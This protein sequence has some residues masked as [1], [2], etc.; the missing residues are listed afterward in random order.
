M[1]YFIVF[2]YFGK[3]YHGWQ[4]QPNALSVQE[5]MEDVFSTLLRKQISLTA[6]GRTDTGVHARKMVAHADLD[7]PEQPE[8]LVRRLNSFLP[9]DI[10]VY[11]FIPVKEDAHARFDAIE[12]SYEYWISPKKNP[13]YMDTAYHLRSPLELSKMNEAASLLLRF[14]DFECFSKSNTDVKTFLCDIKSAGWVEEEDRIVFRI[15]ADRFLRN[16]V[17]AIVGTLLDVGQGKISV[18]DVKTIIKSKDRSKA[19]VSVP[20]KG[21]YLTEV[22]YPDRILKIDG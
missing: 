12:R 14:D 11:S 5:V 7:L 21:L 15:T 2:S 1:R 4:R 18:A 3:S 17:R 22:K 10:A 8:E 19:G 13:F 16:M 20:A 6:A 9:E